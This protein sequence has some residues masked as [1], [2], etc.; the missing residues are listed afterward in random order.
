VAEARV[1]AARWL[2]L[3]SINR[4]GDLRRGESNFDIR[5]GDPHEGGWGYS[6]GDY[7]DR[8]TMVIVFEGNSEV[9]ANLIRRD[10]TET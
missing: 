3:L 4:S 10:G 5:G 2:A 9:V 7:G 6:S 1:V 8:I